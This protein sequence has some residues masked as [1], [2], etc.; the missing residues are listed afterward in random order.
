MTLHFRTRPCASIRGAVLALATAWSA[1]GA[2]GATPDFGPDV[3]IFTPGMATADI[4]A[5]VDAVAARQV[6]DQFGPERVALLFMPGTYGSA[7]APL[8]FQ[9]G[10]YTSVA[11]LGRS[12]TDVVVNGSINAYNQCDSTGCY[13]LNNFWRSLGNLDIEVDNAALGCHAGEFWAVSQ[14]SPMRRVRVDGNTTLMD[15][16]TGPSYASGGFIADSKFDGGTVI[17]GSQ[18]QWIT[19][20]SAVDGWTNGVWN[21]VFSGVLGAPGTCFPGSTGCGGP[22]TTL[23]T[24]PVTREAPYLYVDAQGGWNG[25]APATRRDS[26]GTTWADGPTAGRSVPLSRFFIAR[27]TDSARRINEA[28]LLGRNL[29]LT[30]GVYRL[31]EPLLVPWRDTIVLGLGYPTLVPQHG[32]AALAIASQPGIDVSGVL[33][34]AGPVRSRVLV[35]V[36]NPLRLP[37]AATSRPGAEPIALHDVFLRIG[38]A[39][40]GSAGTAMVVDA[41][42]VI[43]DD[44]WA[45]RADHGN[46]VGWTSNRADTGLV[47]NGDDVTAYGLFV[48]HFQKT[49]TLW[50][51]ERGRVVFYQNEMPYDPPSQSAWNES[52]TV[53]GYP[54]LKVADHVRRFNGWGLGSYNFFNQGV[55][56]YASHAFEVPASLPAGSLQDLLTVFLDP[57]KGRGGVLD[58]ID[59]AGGPATI[60]NPSTPVTVTAFP[61]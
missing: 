52:R 3:H 6:P 27:P 56:I 54:A 2:F 50:N 24:S 25:F 7:S 37:F 1:A 14:A 30:P 38:G 4:Q 32:N 20:D 29:I 47:V 51:G 28:L 35:Q 53:L 40:A 60:A 48:E 41:D 11:G 13:A 59:N 12:P 31:D 36:G 9:V 44:V 58:V 43:L 10:Y 26:S 22:Y 19:R 16:C 17:S 34:D 5:T 55:D 18:Q 23:A 8:N 49:E 61:Q 45:W 15:Y 46:G 33:V 57:S 39:Q 21:Q 42:N